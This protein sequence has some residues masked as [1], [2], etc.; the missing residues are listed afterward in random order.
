MTLFTQ[1]VIGRDYLDF[2]ARQ[3]LAHLRQQNRPIDKIE[4]LRLKAEFITSP[5]LQNSP[6]LV[7]YKAGKQGVYAKLSEAEQ[8]EVNSAVYDPKL[9]VMGV[10]RRMKELEKEEQQ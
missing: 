1:T 2:I 7:E 3:A 9:I 4:F 8:S 6:A 10:Y 5:E